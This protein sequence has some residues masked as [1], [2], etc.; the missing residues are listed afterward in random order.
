MCLVCLTARFDN[1]FLNAKCVLG[2]NLSYPMDSAGFLN[3]EALALA[4]E[5]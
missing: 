2:L 1:P 5:A 4:L 3:K